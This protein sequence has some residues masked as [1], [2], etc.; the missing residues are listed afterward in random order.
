MDILS[1]TWTPDVNMLEIQ[2][3][4]GTLISHRADRSKVQCPNCHS[5]GNLHDIRAKEVKEHKTLVA[6][7]REIESCCNP[8][9]PISPKY[10]DLSKRDAI[11]CTLWDLMSDKEKTE[12]ASELEDSDE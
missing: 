3:S 1:A 8:T 7:Y 4:C 6:R 2:C 9:G 10:E 5:K 11:L 12:I